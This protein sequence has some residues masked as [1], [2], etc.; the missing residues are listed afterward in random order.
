MLTQT[1]LP[2]MVRWIPQVAPSRSTMANAA[3]VLTVL[4][5]CAL[6]GKRVVAVADR[7]DEVMLVVLGDQHQGREGG[8]SSWIKVST[9]HGALGSGSRSWRV[10]PA[11]CQWACPAGAIAQLWRGSHRP[12]SKHLPCGH[13]GVETVLLVAGAC[14]GQPV[15]GRRR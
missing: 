14:D 4:G 11:A 9:R 12:W 10:D 13:G 15:E 3:A 7:D 6:L 8:S 2:R 5:G 1:V